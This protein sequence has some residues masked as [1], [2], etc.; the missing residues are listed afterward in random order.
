[1]TVS[2]RSDGA[3]GLAADTK[4]TSVP[5]N[6]K[7]EETDTGKIFYYNGSSWV[8]GAGGRADNM[9]DV[10]SDETSVLKQHFIEWFS[11]GAMPAIW[12]FRNVAGTGSSGMV[13]LVDEGAFVNAG[14]N[15]NDRSSIDFNSKRQ[16]AHNASVAICVFRR[17][18]AT[19]A[20]AAGFTDDPTY[21]ANDDRAVALDATNQTHKCLYTGDG[22]TE[23]VQLSDVAIDTNWTV[24]K[25]VLGSSDIKLYINGVLKV[26]KTSNRP[27]VKLQPSVRTYNLGGAGSRSTRVRYFE[28]YNT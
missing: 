4:P 19:A 17:A 24:Y 26:T 20:C 22:T 16:Y 7:F 23:S 9:Y 6:T 25:I 5:T 28:A 11:G 1:M 21:P 8:E 15:S 12:T 14:A 27:A 2:W 3:Y 13:D 10:F 18:E